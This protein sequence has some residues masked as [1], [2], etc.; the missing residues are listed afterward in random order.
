M[1]K[2]NSLKY[3]FGSK[4]KARRVG[5]GI[6]STLGK[7]SGK[8]HKGQK[9]R[10]GAKIKPGFEGGQTPLHRRLPKYGF[11]SYLSK[12]TQELRLDAL[13]KIDGSE[14]SFD[15]LKQKGF[16]KKS[17]KRV[18][19]INSGEINRKIILINIKATKAA[20]ASIEKKGGEV[21]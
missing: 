17:T 5:R 1:N 14:I 15:L 2:L 21:R 11:S 16:I 7:T 6:G 20:I 13:N 18:K 10:S 3:D 4:H 12:V 19:I 8:G 9:A